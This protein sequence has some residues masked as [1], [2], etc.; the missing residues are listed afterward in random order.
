MRDRVADE[1]EPAPAAGGM[2][3]ALG[4]IALRIVAH[5][6]ILRPGSVIDRISDALVALCSPLTY[7]MT[8]NTIG[9]DG[10]ELMGS[11]SSAI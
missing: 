2:H 5:E 11:R 3:P 6:Q 1:V 10:G 7:W 9:V 8:G 4:E